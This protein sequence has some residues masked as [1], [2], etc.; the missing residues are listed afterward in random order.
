[1][2]QKAKANAQTKCY[3]S[4]PQFQNWLQVP[5]SSIKHIKRTK[6]ASNILP[7]NWITYFLETQQILGHLGDASP[8]HRR[9][10]HRH[11][12]PNPDLVI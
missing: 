12:G 8:G 5:Y 2:A 1:V 6:L 3:S 10:D 4:D 11:F 7:S 9:L